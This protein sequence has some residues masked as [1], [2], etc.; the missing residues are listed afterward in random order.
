MFKQKLTVAAANKSMIASPPLPGEC[1]SR[2][3]A[4]SWAPDLHCAHNG[5]IFQEVL[6]LQSAADLAS[7][8]AGKDLV[9]PTLEVCDVAESPAKHSGR[10]RRQVITEQDQDGATVTFAVTVPAPGTSLTEN[11]SVPAKR[12]TGV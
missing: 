10:A 1:W 2:Q 11:E 12:G 8:V 3:R 9:P 5:L 7:Y 6:A 4:S